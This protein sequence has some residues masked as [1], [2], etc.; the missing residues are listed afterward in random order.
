MLEF[1]IAL[2]LRL[3]PLIF[4]LNPAQNEA[5]NLLCTLGNFVLVVHASDYSKSIHA[6][7]GLSS[8]PSMRANFFEVSQHTESV[9]SV[10]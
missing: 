8:Q 2:G 5:S 4:A 6:I 10:L 9:F 3:T 1:L 7:K